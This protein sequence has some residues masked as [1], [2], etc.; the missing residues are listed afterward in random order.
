MQELI[1]IIKMINL[2]GIMINSVCNNYIRHFQSHIITNYL[3]E[4]FIIYRYIGCLAFN[5]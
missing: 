2:A 4:N 1:F 3:V 5:N